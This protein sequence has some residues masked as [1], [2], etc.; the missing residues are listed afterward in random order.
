MDLLKEDIGRA[1]GLLGWTEGYALIGEISRNFITRKAVLCLE[2]ALNEANFAHLLRE[3]IDDPRV[4][5]TLSC[6]WSAIVLLD[7]SLE[8]VAG[9]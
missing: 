9:R 3:E 1:K 5:S 4:G 2:Y 8:R 6:I 7:E